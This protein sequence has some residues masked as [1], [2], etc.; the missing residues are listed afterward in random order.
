MFTPILT[1]LASD[2]TS[3]NDQQ[4]VMIKRAIKGVREPMTIDGRMTHKRNDYVIWLLRIFRIAMPYRL[5]AAME[6]YPL[7]K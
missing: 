7:H 6:L 4:A 2:P 3:W 5:S 1:G